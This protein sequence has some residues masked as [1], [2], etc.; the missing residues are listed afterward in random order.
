MGGFT[1]TTGA[2]GLSFT[3]SLAGRQLASMIRKMIIKI[4]EYFFMISFF[5]KID[6]NNTSRFKS[7]A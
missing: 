3:T 1:S 4:D 2:T 7:G 6:V 5:E